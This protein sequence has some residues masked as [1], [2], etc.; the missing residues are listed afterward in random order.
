M[1]ARQR[2]RDLLKQSARVA[3]FVMVVDRRG[4]SAA[5]LRRGDPPR[6]CVISTTA[7]SGP[8]GCGTRTRSVAH[9]RQSRSG[10][11]IEQPCRP[12]PPHDLGERP[13]AEAEP[14]SYCLRPRDA[15]FLRAAQQRQSALSPH[16]A[17]ELPR[18]SRHGYSFPAVVLGC[19]LQIPP[20]P[21]CSVE[22][23]YRRRRCPSR[24]T[25]S[26]Q[27]CST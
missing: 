20:G 25:R 14:A 11:L 17:G 13:A 15:R 6:L 23:V 5:D 22:R 21:L 2:H 12:Q 19:P 8:V 18:W 3:A 10:S 16:R 4:E 24:S 7:T 26:T 1:Q 27:Y 9:G